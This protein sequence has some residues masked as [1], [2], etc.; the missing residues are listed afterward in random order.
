MPSSENTEWKPP[1]KNQW[2]RTKSNSTLVLYSMK[3]GEVKRIYHDDLSCKHNVNGGWACSLVMAACK[4]KQ[5]GFLF[6]DHVL[7]ARRIK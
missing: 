6:K 1:P 2:H 7:V 4:L 3:V 5:E